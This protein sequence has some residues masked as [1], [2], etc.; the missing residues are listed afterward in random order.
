MDR[1]WGR[2]EVAS[3][4]KCTNR[5]C[6]TCR[7]GSNAAS[8]V[9]VDEAWSLGECLSRTDH[10][11]PGIPVFF[12]LSKNTPFKKQFLDGDIPLL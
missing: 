7:Y 3:H 8:W 1:K 12:V 5:C 9:L 10:V 6:N 2:A 4:T 11:V